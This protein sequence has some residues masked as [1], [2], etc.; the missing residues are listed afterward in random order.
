MS[1]CIHDMRG[2]S[3]PRWVSGP[4]AYVR[5]HGPTELKYAG[6]YTHAQLRHWAGQI[7]EF[8]DAG[9]DVFVYFNNDNAGYAAANAKELQGLLDLTVARRE[10]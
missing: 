3:C 4:V 7:R 2:F 9:R 8:R 5:F 1:Y 10:K 6:R